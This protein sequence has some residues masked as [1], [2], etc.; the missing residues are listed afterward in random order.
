MNGPYAMG[1]SGFEGE[2]RAFSAATKLMF[3]KNTNDVLDALKKYDTLA[4]AAVLAT[5]YI[6]RL[7]KHNRMKEI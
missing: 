4:A 7:I 5:V 3:A 2:D 6:F 1:W